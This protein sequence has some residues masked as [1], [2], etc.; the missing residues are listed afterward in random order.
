MG[1][2]IAVAF[3]GDADVGQENGEDVFVQHPRIVELDG[4]N[5]QSFLVNFGGFGAEAAGHTAAHV[6]PVAGVGHVAEQL[7]AV[8][9]RFDHAH[10]HEMGAAGIGVVD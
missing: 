7:I 10:I 6:G 2:E 3:F 5:A 8:E 4:W 9:K 1:F